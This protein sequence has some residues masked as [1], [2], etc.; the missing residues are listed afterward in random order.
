MFIK[1]N[2]IKM[3]CSLSVEKELSHPIKLWLKVGEARLKTGARRLK[4][5]AQK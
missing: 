2:K 3:W 1:G 5:F 4:L